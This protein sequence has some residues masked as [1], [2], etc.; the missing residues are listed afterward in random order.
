MF[1]DRKQTESSWTRQPAHQN[2]MWRESAKFG[3]ELTA[4][5]IISRISTNV[6]TLDL[7]S[8]HPVFISCGECQTKRPAILLLREEVVKFDR[9]SKHQIVAMSQTVVSVAK[10]EPRWQVYVG[11]CWCPPNMV[12]KSNGELPYEDPLSRIYGTMGYSIHLFCVVNEGKKL[13]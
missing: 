11:S 2:G 6:L 5:P 7:I 8:D 10:Y 9:E 3:N 4:C 13:L 1:W 12:I